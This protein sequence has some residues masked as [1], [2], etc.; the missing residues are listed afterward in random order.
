VSTYEAESSVDPVKIVTF[1][2]LRKQHKFGQLDAEPTLY[3]DFF[4][5]VTVDR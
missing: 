3:E 1:R 2:R 5:N 4:T